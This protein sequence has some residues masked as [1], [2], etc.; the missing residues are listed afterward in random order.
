MTGETMMTW[1]LP[2]LHLKTTTMTMMTMTM[3]MTTKTIQLFSYWLFS[4]HQQQ[5]QDG[6]VFV[7]VRLIFLV[8]GG[9]WRG[10]RESRMHRK[11]H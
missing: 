7:V 1:T 6:E 9:R 11:Q 10:S 2:T 5:Q 4:F 3:T 8:I